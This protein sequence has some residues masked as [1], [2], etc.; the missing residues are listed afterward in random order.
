MLRLV[1]LPFAWTPKASMLTRVFG[2]CAAAAAALLLVPGPALFA[3]QRQARVVSP[4][5]SAD[6]RVT[7]RF[8][9]PGAREVH[10]NMEGSLKPLPMQ[11]DDQGVWSVTTDPLA[12]EYYG[13]S[14]VADGVSL[15]DP[16]NPLLRPNLLGSGSLVHV[17]GPAS[18]PWETRDVPHGVVHHVLYHSNVVGDDRDFYV[19]TP[20]GYDARG[21]TLYPVLYLQHGFSDDTSAWTSIARANV[22]EDN[23]IADGKA[24]PMIIVMPDGYGVDSI[25]SRTGPGLRDPGVSMENYNKY[26]DALLHEVIP[27][28]EK[29]Y[30]VKADREHR[31]MS[32][33]SMGGAETLY[34][35]LNALDTFSY[36]GAFS[37][38]GLP[39]NYDQLFP[40]M[41]P[42]MNAKLHVLWMSCGTDDRLLKPNENIRD[43]LKSKGVN[44]RWSTSP[45][46]HWW[47]VWRGNL[48]NF[49]PLLFQQ[50]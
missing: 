43:F 42:A 22:I 24:K 3:Q 40:N 49:L 34:V 48:A 9:D 25:V 27:M 5:V 39:T 8:R 20:P 19:Y 26:R 45:G 13:Y 15:I 21:K 14:F 30:R 23:L 17:P 50:Q 2:L 38:G 6:H 7:F 10:V 1:K 46:A 33:L 44:V 18:L 41:G 32:G 31:A 36:I 29:M 4:E 16:E 12:P 35:G 37:S 11:K 28:A 47:P